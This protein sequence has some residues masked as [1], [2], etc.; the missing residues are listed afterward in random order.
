MSWGAPFAA[1]WNAATDTAKGAAQAAAQTAKSAYDY[2]ATKAVQAYEYTKAKAIAGAH[3]VKEKA[4]QGAIYARDKAVEGAVYAKEKAVQG[5][6]LAKDAAGAAARGVGRAAI[7]ARYY[8]ALGPAGVAKLAYDKAR[9]AL[10]MDEAGSSVANCPACAAKCAKLQEALNKAEIAEDTY[11]DD[12]KTAGKV[13]GYDR[14][15]PI[16]DA[17]ELKRLGIF[18]PK[19]QLD[20]EESDFRASIYKRV[21]G[22][23]TEY[24]V[25]FRGTAPR[26]G[27][28]NNLKEGANIREDVTQALGL[29]SPGDRSA[30][31]R[32]IKLATKVSR[33]AR[34]QGASVS[35]TGHSLGGGMASAAAAQTGNPAT[36]YN[37]AGLHPNTVG[38]RIPD[39][40]GEVEAIFSPTDPLSLVQ[41]NTDLP[42]AHGK[43]HVVPFPD[44]GEVQNAKDTHGMRL[45]MEGIK[46]EQK[47]AKCL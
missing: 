13:G 14:L 10:G 1:V 27:L 40:G 41:D 15:D 4:V 35:Y 46:Q 28:L 36:S 24:V 6:G 22:G 25:G 12:G 47:D 39:D 33:N 45:V 5:Y 38:G 2:T 29:N 34:K 37:A 3:Y 32:A 18:D 21:V 23:K 7:E 42:K 44:G 31:D 20:P 26:E 30:Y 11:T 16:K 19:E 17:D 9:E 43:R 8:Q